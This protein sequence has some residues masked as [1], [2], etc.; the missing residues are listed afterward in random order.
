MTSCDS[1][2][3][4]VS[5]LYFYSCITETKN[6]IHC[7]SHPINLLHQCALDF[8]SLIEL[9]TIGDHQ[10]NRIITLH[11]LS[12]SPQPSRGE[13]REL[14]GRPTDRIAHRYADQI[15][16]CGKLS[17]IYFTVGTP[18][19]FINDITYAVSLELS[20]LVLQEHRPLLLVPFG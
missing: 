18:L 10:D 20:Q 16:T 6:I 19:A 14:D 5:N 17:G 11:A 12:T 3:T 1:S 7:F 15:P 4:L 9:K 8:C 2:R 13:A